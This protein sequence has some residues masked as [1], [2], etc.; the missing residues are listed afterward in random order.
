V[1]PPVYQS[2]LGTKAPGS[3][4]SP[5]VPLLPAVVFADLSITVLFFGD[6][7]GSRSVKAA[8]RASHQAVYSIAILTQRRPTKVATKDRAAQGAAARVEMR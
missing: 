3:A 7:A 6:V 4:R 8:Q 1:G 2:L 5:S